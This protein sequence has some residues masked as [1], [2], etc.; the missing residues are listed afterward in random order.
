MDPNLS[1]CKSLATIAPQR[2]TYLGS[3]NLAVEVHEMILEYV[4]DDLPDQILLTSLTEFGKKNLK[5]GIFPDIVFTNKLLYHVG[6]LTFIRHSQFVLGF[7]E[8]DRGYEHACDIFRGFL[9]RFGG[10]IDKVQRL[11]FDYVNNSTLLSNMSI[12]QFCHKFPALKDLRLEFSG[13]EV[14]ENASNSIQ[15]FRS[16]GEILLDFQLHSLFLLPKLQ[17]LSISLKFCPSITYAI[18]GIDKVD[19]FV[20]KSQSALVQRFGIFKEGV[21]VKITVDRIR[22]RVG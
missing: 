2:T 3:R 19:E 22:Y 21:E 8:Y 13:Y 7:F 20:G 16:V 17:C 11:A 6:T 15:R 10:G 18:G 9:S 14:I 12:G 5:G 1:P 4:F